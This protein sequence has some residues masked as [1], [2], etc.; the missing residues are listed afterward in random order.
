MSGPAVTAERHGRKSMAWGGKGAVRA[1]E[2]PGGKACWEGSMAHLTP[3]C[4]LLNQARPL[5]PFTH[6]LPGNEVV[7]LL[8]MS[9]H[10]QMQPLVVICWCITGRGLVTKWG[11]LS[12]HSPVPTP[13]VSQIV[14]SSLEMSFVANSGRLEWKNRKQPRGEWLDS[15]KTDQALYLFISL[16]PLVPFH[17]NQCRVK[18]STIILAAFIGFLKFSNTSGYHME[19][20]PCRVGWCRCLRKSDANTFFKALFIIMSPQS[21][22]GANHAVTMWAEKLCFSNLA[23]LLFRLTCSRVYMKKIQNSLWTKCSL[24]SSEK[25][26]MPRK[27]RCNITLKH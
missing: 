25:C 7:Q 22:K 23:P 24:H 10:S 20:L 12:F 27:T 3:A 19:P 14:I 18:F 1:E 16:I 17:I 9:V 21:T 13:R 11:K 5:T 15:K 4:P 26:I 2:S 8:E 6:S